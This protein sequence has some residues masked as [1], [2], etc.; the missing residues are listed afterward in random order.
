MT[1]RFVV[2]ENIYQEKRAES[3]SRPAA[4]DLDNQSQHVELNAG[5]AWG[6]VVKL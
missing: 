1:G 4:E 3:V 6:T 5:Y 2:K